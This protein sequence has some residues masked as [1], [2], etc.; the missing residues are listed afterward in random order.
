MVLVEIEGIINTRPLTYLYDDDVSEPLTPSHLLTGRN[1]ADAPNEDA[2]STA[3]DAETMTNRF[4]YL[5][6]TL[7]SA[8]KKFQHHYLTELREHH[9]YTRRKTNDG[10]VLKVGDVVIVKDDD[11]RSRNLW[12]LGR[13][14]S[15]VVGK[16]DQVRGA[17]LS[18]IS[19]KFRHTKMPRPLQKIIPLEVSS[20]PT[21]VTS[22]PTDVTNPLRNESLPEVVDHDESTRSRRACAVVGESRRRAKNQM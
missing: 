11:V 4:R 8:W 14:E 7:Q 3:S 6:T 17:N 15:L 1:L 2:P 12:R 21:D 22:D 9:M 19:K 5:Q 20:D 18:T 16:D 13:V 10:N